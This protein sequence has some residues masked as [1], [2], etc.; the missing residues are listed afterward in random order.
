MEVVATA[1]PEVLLLKPRAFGDERGWFQETYQAERYRALGIAATFVQDNLSF[2]RRGV[3]RG[4]HLQDPHPQGKLVYVLVGEVFD[5]AVD[6]R[7]HSPT[8]G[9]WV[10][11]CLSA[12]NRHQLWIPPG[13]AHGF[14]VLSETALFAYKCTDYYHPEAERCLRWDDPELAI[15]WP[16]AEPVV[17]AKDRAGLPLAAF[18]ASPG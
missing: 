12:A 5:V 9:R 14:C 2:S 15:P 7:P 10:A 3:L 18:R 11:E 8:F 6:L 1:L 17:S 4:L 16:V 13:F